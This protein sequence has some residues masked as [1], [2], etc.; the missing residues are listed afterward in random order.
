MNSSYEIRASMTVKTIV[1]IKAI[2]GARSSPSVAADKSNKM[3]LVNHAMS[4]TT[5]HIINGCG[6]MFMVSK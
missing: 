3:S 4:S 6:K 2:I 1:P 5:G